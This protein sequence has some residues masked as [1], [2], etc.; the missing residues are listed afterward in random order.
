MIRPL[1]IDTDIKPG[2]VGEMTVTPDT[3]GTFTAICD[4]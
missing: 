2:K 1:K 4:H 3:T